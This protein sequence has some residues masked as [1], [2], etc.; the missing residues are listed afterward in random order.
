LYFEYFHILFQ[1]PHEKLHRIAPLPTIFSIH[2]ILEAFRY[3]CDHLQLWK[4][5]RNYSERYPQPTP[6]GLNMSNI[7]YPFTI[8][9]GFSNI[10]FYENLVTGSL[11]AFM[12]N[13]PYQPPPVILY[14]GFCSVTPSYLAN[15]L[16]GKKCHHSF[17]LAVLWSLMER[18]LCPT[19]IDCLWLRPYPSFTFAMIFT[20]FHFRHDPC[21]KALKGL[22]F[23][24]FPVIID[25]II[26]KET[27]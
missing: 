19:V 9:N 10:R 24:N 11:A 2:Y 22:A 16:V 23:G 7:I 18:H 8:K 3:L 13:P 17:L 27:I 25:I 4:I 26:W 14:N 21:A 5:S 6:G 12:Y 1:I 20:M 15:L